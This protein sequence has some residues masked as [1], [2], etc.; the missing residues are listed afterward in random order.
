MIATLTIVAAILQGILH[1][2]LTGMFL[3]IGF[4]MSKIITTK[5]DELRFTLNKSFMRE[6]E[7]SI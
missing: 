6:L 5:L 7:A 3:G 2:L 1:L 4:W